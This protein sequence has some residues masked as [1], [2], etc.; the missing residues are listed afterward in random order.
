MK[1]SYI[2][3]NQIMYKEIKNGWKEKEKKHPQMKA[4][5]SYYRNRIL[6]EKMMA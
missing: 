6:G 5:F 1:W 2:G 4:I 3:H